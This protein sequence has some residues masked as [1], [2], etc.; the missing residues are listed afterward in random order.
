MSHFSRSWDGTHL[1][2]CALEDTECCEEHLPGLHR[3]VHV[4]ENEAERLR[5]AIGTWQ[6]S[7]RTFS[8]HE[9]SCPSMRDATAPCYCGVRQRDYEG[10]ISADVNLEAVLTC[11][12]PELMT[13]Q[14][15][16]AAEMQRDAIKEQGL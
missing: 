4:L 8:L 9:S 15:V 5:E 12:C 6:A 16:G 11:T 14:A 7:R 3:R 2:G 13:E 10:R 1:E